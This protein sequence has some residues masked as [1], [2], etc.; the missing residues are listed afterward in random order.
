MP[1]S[2]IAAS[3]GPVPNRSPDAG[4]PPPCCPGTTRD[5]EDDVDGDGTDDGSSGG[6]IRSAP[7][8]SVPTALGTAV[9]AGSRSRSSSADSPHPLVTVI[10]TQAA[11]TGRT[12]PPLARIAIIGRS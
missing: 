6:S 11:T 1:R 12:H 7:D 5:G 4:H 8:P 3:T 10:T 2:P 9:R